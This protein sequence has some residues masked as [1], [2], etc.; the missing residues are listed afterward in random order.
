MDLEKKKDFYKQT[1]IA[2]IVLFLP[3]ILAAGPLA[4]HFAGEYLRKKF[5]LGQSVSVICIAAGFVSSILETV[6]LIKLAVKIDK[7]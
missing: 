1:R 3:F 4:G 7:S 5:N 6:R 2:G